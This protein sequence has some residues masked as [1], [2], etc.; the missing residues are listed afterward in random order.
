[1]KP[2]IKEI[3]VVEGKTD[4]IKL[5]S[6]F[7]VDTIETNGSYL[8]RE[9][10]VLIQ[11]AANNRGVILFLDPDGPGEAIRRKL[12]NNLITYKQAFINK[13][14]ITDKKKIGV[15]EA[16][17]RTIVNAFQNLVTFHKP[18]DSIGWDE[19]LQH[20]WNKAKRKIVADYFKI[21][22]STNK[23]LF[24]RLNMMGIDNKTLKQIISSY[25]VH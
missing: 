23:R 24:K 4:T 9:T 8:S 16:D 19:Y 1:M 3:V 11:K 5:Q 20:D 21:S 25:K 6:L 22:E 18:K 10:I 17:S 7:D 12:E 15:A 14:D 13:A 2:S